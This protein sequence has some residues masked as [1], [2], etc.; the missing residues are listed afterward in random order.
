MKS[1]GFQHDLFRDFANCGIEL[2]QAE[3]ETVQE[4]FK[5]LERILRVHGV[6]LSCSDQVADYLKL[7]IATRPHES[8]VVLFLDSQHR[9]IEAQEMY[10]G[11]INHISVFPRDIAEQALRLNAGACILCCNRPAGISQDTSQ[12]QSFSHKI[13]DALAIFDIQVLDYVT[14]S[15]TNHQSLTQ[16][17]LL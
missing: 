9:L 8:F 14:I 11:T 3:Q 1:H 4:A 2:S 13:K 10:R 17:G 12:D 5:I 7:T 15:G 6:G 16:L